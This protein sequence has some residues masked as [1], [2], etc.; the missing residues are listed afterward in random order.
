[1]KCSFI[2]SANAS[3]EMNI[4]FDNITEIEDLLDCLDRV[5][6]KVNELDSLN[7]NLSH[8]HSSA[9]G[10]VFNF[11]YVL[12]KAELK[13]LLHHIYACKSN[14]VINAFE[15]A[16]LNYYTNQSSNA[17]FTHPPVNAYM[18]SNPF[19][20]VSIKGSVNI[21]AAPVIDKTD[22]SDW[23][24]WAHNREGECRCGIHRSQCKYH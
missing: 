11:Q 12:D 1:M 18:Q 17:H 22:M 2:P 9:P 16:Y 5:Y 13:S 15:E 19:A 21:P 24:N 6:M 3:V 10:T 4:R 23:R 7:D 8:R 14:D 20:N